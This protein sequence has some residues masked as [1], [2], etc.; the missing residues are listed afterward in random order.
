MN[1]DV[2]GVVNRISDYQMRVKEITIAVI[3]ASLFIETSP[4]YLKLAVTIIM[5]SLWVL[6]AYY[7]SIE[8]NIRKKANLENLGNRVLRQ[9]ETTLNNLFATSVWIFHVTFILVSVFLLLITLFC[10]E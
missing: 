5:I 6:D 3:T 1:Q 4:W 7:L 10:T 9:K 2:Q 8:R